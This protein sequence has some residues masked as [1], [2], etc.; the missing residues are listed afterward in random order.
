M[1]VQKALSTWSRYSVK[2]QGIVLVNHG[3]YVNSMQ[4]TFDDASKFKKI[5][6]DP[7]ITRLAT[8][9]YYLKTLRKRAEIT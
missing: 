8:V 5:E 2:G 3:D 1:G 6:K 9:Q 7:I 4:K